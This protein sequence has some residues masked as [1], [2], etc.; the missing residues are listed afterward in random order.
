[1]I[2]DEQIFYTPAPTPTQINK[3]PFNQLI[4]HSLI[5]LISAEASIKPQFSA[6]LEIAQIKENV[7]ASPVDVN[8]ELI[9]Y[10][11]QMRFRIPDLIVS[12]FHII[13]FVF[14]SQGVDGRSQCRRL[15]MFQNQTSR[16]T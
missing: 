11:S 13:L 3:D 10:Q 12:A 9:L 8:N 14:V 15:A 7:T 4:L 1:M 2:F 16:K 6:S 5:P